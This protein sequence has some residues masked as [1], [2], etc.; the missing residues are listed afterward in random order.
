[1]RDGYNQCSSRVADS[2]QLGTWEADDLSQTFTAVVFH[3]MYGS[4]VRIM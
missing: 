4:H 2:R 1:M 3:Q